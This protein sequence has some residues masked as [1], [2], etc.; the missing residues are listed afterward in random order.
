M[1]PSLLTVTSPAPARLFDVLRATV[2]TLRDLNQSFAL[3]GGLAVSARTEPRFTRDID[4]AV[5]VPDDAM[6]ER[7]IADLSARGFRLDRSLEQ[8]AI[9]RL[10]SVRLTPPSETTQGVVVDLLFASSAIEDEICAA[11]E[12]IEIARGTTLPIATSGH[13]IVMKVLSRCADRPQ[14]Q[15]DAVALVKVLNDVERTRA[16]SAAARIERL[17][18]NR[19]KQ[20]EAEVEGM[21]RDLPDP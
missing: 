21:L 19:G 9:Q 1:V 7:L 8:R 17:G 14:D 20:L 16:R 13:L 2:S 4:L 5:A 3:V 18:A 10:A 15:M 12:S 11:A 6:A